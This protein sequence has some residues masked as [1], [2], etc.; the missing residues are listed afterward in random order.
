MNATQLTKQKTMVARSF[1]ME[2]L[3]VVRM[4]G[5]PLPMRI[6]M[7]VTFMAVNTALSDAVVQEFLRARR[8]MEAVFAAGDLEP[9]NFQLK[10]K[11]TPVIVLD[12]NPIHLIS[13]H[14]PR[15][16]EY[17]N[18]YLQG[19]YYD[20]RNVN[21]AIP[22]HSTSTAQTFYDILS[23][24]YGSLDPVH[25]FPLQNSVRQIR[26]LNLAIGDYYQADIGVWRRELLE[27]H[28]AVLVMMRAAWMGRNP[29]REYDRF[30]HAGGAYFFDYPALCP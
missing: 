12:L 21:S 14:L 8:L 5:Q 23:T 2:R 13:C 1:N 28:T 16:W 25:H 29:L 7:P 19:S 30:I 24:K 11:I 20:P 26:E 18:F 22:Y 9:E 4:F 10:A 17:Q 15:I 27:Y 6:V 3:Q